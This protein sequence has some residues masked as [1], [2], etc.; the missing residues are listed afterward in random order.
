MNDEG[1]YEDDE[2]IEDLRAAW[3]AGEKGTTAGPRDLNKRATSI[4]DR[5]VARFEERQEVR[6]RVVAS[7]TSAM[8]ESRDI[9]SGTALVVLDE[10]VS[11]SVYRVG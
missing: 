1:F 9:G 11:A 2:P 10:V 4:I 7:G 6:L 3:K 8:T 5:T